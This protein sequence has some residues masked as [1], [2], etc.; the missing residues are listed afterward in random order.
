MDP[1]E[2][3]KHMGFLNPKREHQNNSPHLHK[4]G[5]LHG[6]TLAAS[7]CVGANP[8]SSE[9]LGSPF[10]TGLAEHHWGQDHKLELQM[11]EFSFFLTEYFKKN[12]HT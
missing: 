9:T 2:N 3:D 10:R 7:R 11:G 4:F 1:Y 12:I 5:I 6:S 8:A